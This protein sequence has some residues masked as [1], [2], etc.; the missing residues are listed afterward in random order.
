MYKRQVFN[1][2]DMGLGTSE[3]H[4][5]ECTDGRFV[6]LA[7]SSNQTEVLSY[8][9]AVLSEGMN[10]REILS[11]VSLTATPGLVQAVSDFNKTNDRYKAVSYTHLDVYKRQVLYY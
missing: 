2:S 1:W 9:M 4:L 10:E 3:V 11:M 5:G 7:A 6:V 8:E